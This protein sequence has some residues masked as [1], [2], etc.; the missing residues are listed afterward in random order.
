MKNITKQKFLE[1]HNFYVQLFLS[2]PPTFF[3]F[4]PHLACY[5]VL[6]YL[7]CINRIIKV[8]SCWVKVDYMNNTSKNLAVL[9]HGA[10]ES[11]LKHTIQHTFQQT[12]NVTN[13]RWTQNTMKFDWVLSWWHNIS[14]LAYQTWVT[15]HLVSSTST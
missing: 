14:I 10:A 12:L 11:W 15:F 9:Y 3:D 7:T 6:L 8:F 1:S 4:C 2:P 5:L 13:F